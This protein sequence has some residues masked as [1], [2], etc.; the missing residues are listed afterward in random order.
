VYS[1]N[2]SFVIYSEKNGSQDEEWTFAS[3]KR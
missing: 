3:F 1:F 2:V